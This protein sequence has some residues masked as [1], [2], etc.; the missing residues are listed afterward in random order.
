MLSKWGKYVT[1]PNL[2]L[3]RTDET[4]DDEAYALRFGRY[5]L[6]LLNRLEYGDVTISKHAGSLHKIRTQEDIR[7]PENLKRRVA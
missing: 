6:S 3:V 7:P 4:E 5:I 1:M 2:S